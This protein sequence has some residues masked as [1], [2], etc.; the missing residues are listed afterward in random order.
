MLEARNHS[1]L[2]VAEGGAVEQVLEKGEDVIK[3]IVEGVREQRMSLIQTGRQFVFVY[4]AV[5]AG[6]LR[7]LR[8][9]GVN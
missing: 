3:A 6:L 4:S 1:Q 8:S 7:D 5:L 9:E 2:S